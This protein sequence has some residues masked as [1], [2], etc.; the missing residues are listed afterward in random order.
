[1]NGEAQRMRRLVNDLLDAARTDSSG[2]AGTPTPVDLLGLAREVAAEYGGPL[3]P[4][5]V[6][7]SGAVISG[8]E[9]RLRQ[10]LS[11]L[12]DNAV[13]YS[14]DGGEI[15]VGVNASRGRAL[16]EVTDNGIG[17]PQAEQEQIFERF[18]RG[19]NSSDR[20]FTG[21]GLG[22]YLCSEIVRAHGG[23]ISLSSVEGKGTTMRLTFPIAGRIEGTGH[24]AAHTRS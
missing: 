22:L 7:G 17:I 5:R 3:H 1:M 10:V 8:D 16:L 21:L 15:T 2:Y 19:S 23:L 6:T 24:V 18:R 12:L 11:N 4:V 9:G 20:R 13:K 14:P